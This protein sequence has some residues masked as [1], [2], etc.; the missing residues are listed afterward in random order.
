VIVALLQHQNFP[1]SISG[2]I[3]SRLR[4][5]YLPMLSSSILQPRSTLAPNRLDIAAPAHPSGCRIVGERVVA[6]ARFSPPERDRRLHRRRLLGGEGHG[7]GAESRRRRET[8]LSRV[9][10]RRRRRSRPDRRVEPGARS[11]ARRAG[12]TWQILLLGRS[13][14]DFQP[15]AIGVSAIASLPLLI[16]GARAVEVRL[17]A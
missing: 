17:P 2:E 7:G 13:V 3:P 6:R 11:A 12:D 15:S 1:F 10:R 4:W 9:F 5:R 8:L 16:R 14:Q